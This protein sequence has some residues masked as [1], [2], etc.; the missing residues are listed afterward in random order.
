MFDNKLRRL[1]LAAAALLVCFGAQADYTSPDGKFRMSG[2]GT[3]GYS[4]SSTDDVLF[5]YKGQGGGAKKSGSFHPDS[6]VAVQGTYNFT[7]Q[8]SGTAQIMTKYDAEGEYIPTFEW[9]FLKWQALPSLTFRGGKMGAP[10]FMVSDFRDVG[11]ANT[12]VR[13]P[14]DVYAQVPVSNFEGVDATHQLSLGSV[15]L[16]SSLW[17]GEAR[18]DYSNSLSGAPATIKIKNMRGINLV[19][20][21]DNGISLRFG[22]LQGKLSIG[23]RSS[24]QIKASLAPVI[25][26]AIEGPSP[27]SQAQ[28]RALAAAITQDDDDASFSG[29]GVSYDQ[30]DWVLSAE[31]TK[32]R[33]DGG[34]VAETTGWYTTV[35]HRFG[36]WLPY[37]GYGKVK[38]D[39]PN[40]VMPGGPLQSENPAVRVVQATLDT[41][42][43]AQ[44]TATVGV[45]WDAK[46]GLAVKAQFDRISKPANSYGMFLVANP[47]ADIEGGSQFLN[48]K[49]N[50]NVVTLSVDFVF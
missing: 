10:F 29:I 31:Y 32:R 8:V 49:K 12:A 30:N 48:A 33:I 42:K 21:F 44:N 35:G 5:N 16:S 1:P 43:V 24:D 39:D 36:S 46:P 37:I 38:V 23:S 15:T 27:G 25:A 7:D 13:P 3:L 4:Q 34:Y 41:G 28:A 2:F 45:R 47:V 26:G 50:I 17:L 20:D 22:H 6:K 14:L 18:A 40:A 9:A 19:A 11:Y